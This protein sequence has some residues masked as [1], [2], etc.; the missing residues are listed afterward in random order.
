[1]TNFVLVSSQN[2][3]AGLNIRDRLLENYEFKKSKKEFEGNTVYERENIFLVTSKR[4]IVFADNLDEAFSDSS[5][6]FLS[7]HR[8]ESGIPSLT[9]HFTGNFGTN[10][11]GGREHE[12]S[13]YDPFLLKSYMISLR[14]SPIELN[15]FQMTLEATHHGPTS[16]ERPVLFVELGSSEPQWDDRTA[17]E[18]IGRAVMDSI[19]RQISY[20]SI[21]L[22]IGGTHYSD[23]FNKLIFDSE[24]AIGAIVPKYAL[25]DLDEAML[26]QVLSKSLRKITGAAID[27]KGLGQFK[28]RVLE[29]LTKAGLPII[30][31]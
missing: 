30:K 6:V 24:H 23:K 29:L 15:N 13:H 31:A 19:T 4:D 20:S 8:A 16:L 18:V 12:I 11:F 22:G 10:P 25:E 27:P 21:L 17:A 28:R 14:S 2:D 7:R 9:A 3:I 5:Y 26:A 1:M